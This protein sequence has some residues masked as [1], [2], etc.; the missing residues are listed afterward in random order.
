MIK[1]RVNLYFLRLNL[2]ILK[3]FLKNSLNIAVLRFYE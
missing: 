2:E 1:Y 3:H